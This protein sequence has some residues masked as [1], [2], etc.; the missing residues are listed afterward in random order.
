MPWGMEYSYEFP[1]CAAVLLSVLLIHFFSKRQLP[2]IRNRIFTAAILL[3]FVDA[4]MCLAV[5][6][7]H[8]NIDR[9]PKIFCDAVSAIYLL[10]HV[11]AVLLSTFCAVYALVRRKKR[12]SSGV[13]LIGGGF[14]ICS[15]AI[16]ATQIMR[17]TWFISS[18]AIVAAM[19][20][21]SLVLQRPENMIDHLTGL[22]NL[23]AMMA[24]TDELIARKARYYVIVVKVENIRRINSIFGYAV[25]NLTMRSVA[26][27]LSTFSP[28]LKERSRLR[29]QKTPSS[30]DTRKRAA[31]AD[32]RKLERT[33]PAAWAFRLMSN[34]FAVVSTS[35][36]TH[37]SLLR[38]IQTRFDEPWHIRGLEITLM[39]TVAEMTETGSFATGEDLYRVVEIMMPSLPK[40]DM[41]TL[42]DK[43]L[44]KFNRAIEMESA[45]EQ[46]IST[47]S[48]Q[49]EFQP[50]CA[51]RSGEV[52]FVEALARFKHEKWGMVPPSEFIPIAEKRGLVAQIDEFVLRCSCEWLKQTE[53]M[54]LGVQS[55]HINVSVSEM[56]SQSFPLKVCEILDEYGI[57]RTQIVFEI[58]ESAMMTSLNLLLP[59]LEQMAAMGFTFVVDN[60]SIV[61]ASIG[62]LTVL[63]FSQ[64]KFNR[65]TL[66]AAETSPKDKMLFENLIDLLRKMEVQTVVIGV[67]T[68]EQLDMV[69]ES[70]A[71]FVQGF[72]Y[73]SPMSGEACVEFIKNESSLRERRPTKRE[74]IV[75]TE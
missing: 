25:G 24:Y 44:A 58:E 19:L 7:V 53:K 8:R 32:A 71:D 29:R 14:G 49:V 40:G 74:F 46:A 15:F 30:P 60:M 68:G 51:A 4:I 34:Q 22:L 35:I 63:P 54:E 6:A 10:T 73:A 57:E 28:D 59:N 26:D 64:V 17:P 31:A 67:E 55:V 61:Q 36:F 1:I 47:Q 43:A 45:L 37:E 42:S 11:G 69:V 21:A 27:Y 20:I 50:I 18:F 75:V 70:S 9:L 56:A 72:Y 13:V 16:L 3:S 66:E 52:K 39:D 12:E 33:L 2:L 48:L 65:H 38:T 23:E 62:H 41:V 5:V